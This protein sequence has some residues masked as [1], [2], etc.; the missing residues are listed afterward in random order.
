LLKFIVINTIQKTYH[1]RIYEI[2]SLK[3]GIE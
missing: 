1:N 3:I 2:M